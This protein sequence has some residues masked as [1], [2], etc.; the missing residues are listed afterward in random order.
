MA[1]PVVRAALVAGAEFTDFKQQAA[2]ASR[3]RS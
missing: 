2:A 1:A 3:V